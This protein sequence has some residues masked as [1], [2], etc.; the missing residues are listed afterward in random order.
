[1]HTRELLAEPGT[2]A[3]IAFADA[4]P[5]GH[6]AFYPARE[7]GTDGMPGNWRVRP[8]VPGVAHLWQLFVLPAWWGAGVAPLLH[9]AAIA[10]MRASGFVRARLYTPSGQTRA[11]R[12][13]ERRGWELAAETMNPGLRFR[14]AEYWLHL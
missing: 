10:E 14:V 12:F 5:A 13:Y 9:D 1:V 4:E 7:R 2:W 3:L 8:L 11:R 6:V